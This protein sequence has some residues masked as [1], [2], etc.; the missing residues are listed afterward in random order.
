MTNFEKVRQFMQAMGQ[1]TPDKP[2]FPSQEV[3]ELRIRL[4]EEELQELKE[5]ITARDLVGVADAL[6]D[7]KVVTYGAAVAFGIPADEVFDVIHTSNMA[8][9][10]PD[11]KPIINDGVLRPD[12]PVG[13]VLKPVGWTPPDLAP[14]LGP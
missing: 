2:G 9:L 1:E 7:L 6:G 12:L 8:K 11:G 10:G 13:K 4:I 5:A 3:I 14:V